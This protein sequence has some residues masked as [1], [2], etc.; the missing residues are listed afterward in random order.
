MMSTSNLQC[1]TAGMKRWTLHQ[2]GPVNPPLALVMFIRAQ[3]CTGFSSVA[4]PTFANVR[5]CGLFIL[6]N[7]LVY[8]MLA[9][10]FLHWR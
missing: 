9:I 4:V 5:G 1:L 3:D 7:F 6:A 2:L 8:A 10:A